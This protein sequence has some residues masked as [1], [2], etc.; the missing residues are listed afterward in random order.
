MSGE[1]IF[2]SVQGVAVRLDQIAAYEG[3][4]NTIQCRMMNGTTAVV[5]EIGIRQFEQ[6][7]DTV[8]SIIVLEPLSEGTE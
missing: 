4:E 5:L 6:L 1:V 7:L 3:D 8:P 2:A